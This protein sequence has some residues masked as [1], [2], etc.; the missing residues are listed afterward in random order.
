MMTKIIKKSKFLS[1]I[2]IMA[3]GRSL[4]FGFFNL[5]YGFEIIIHLLKGESELSTLLI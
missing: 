3:N 5:L 1:L 4:S 2:N